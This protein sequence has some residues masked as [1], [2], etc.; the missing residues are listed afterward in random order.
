MRGAVITGSTTARS[1]SARSAH[2][3]AAP[4]AT[5]ASAA[6]GT[7][8]VASRI[9]RTVRSR[10]EHLANLGDQLARRERLGDIRVGAEFE[11]F[12]HLDVTALRRH[13]HHLDVACGGLALELLAYLVAA[14]HRHHDVQKHE[15]GMER[16]REIERFLSARRRRSARAW[17]S[18]PPL[19]RVRPHALARRPYRPEA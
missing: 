8:I 4:P 12:R 17:P 1:L 3:I 18:V 10:A 15:I 2:R 13:H 7:T 9:G 11:R 14:F 6:A 19:V 16:A 5:S